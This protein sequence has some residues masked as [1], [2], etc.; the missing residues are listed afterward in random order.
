M[1]HLITGH[2]IKKAKRRIQSMVQPTP[3]IRDYLLSDIYDKNVYLKLETT[4]TIGA[5]K[6]RGAANKILKL[7]DEEK[8]RGVTTF[9]TGNHGLAVSY[10]AQQLGIPATVC[11]SRHVPKAKCNAIQTFGGILEVYGDSQDEA[12]AKCQT[13][14]QKQ[15]MTIIPPFDDPD[16]IA[17][18]GTIGLELKYDIPKI[19]SVIIPLSGGGLLSGVSLALKLYQ[20]HIH[21]TGVTLSHSAAMLTSIKQGHPTASEEKDTLADSLLGGIGQNNQYTFSMTQAYADD[22]IQADEATIAEGMGYLYDQQKL[23]VEGAAA[24]GIGALLKHQIPALGNHTAVILTGKNLDTK[25][26]SDIITTYMKQK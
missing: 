12:A 26:Y 1:K 17:G 23:I 25:R 9:S 6:V 8:Q 21:I 3:L 2:N 16:I 4:H 24:A 22:I 7:S 18:Q 20:P 19:D 10:V 14:Q 5:F 11:V 13:L 15:G